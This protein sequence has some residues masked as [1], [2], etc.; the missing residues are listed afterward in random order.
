MNNGKAVIWGTGGDGTFNIRLSVN[1]KEELSDNEKK[2]VE[3]SKKDMK[4]VVTGDMV[5]IGSPEAAG[6]NEVR[7]ILDKLDSLTQAEAS[8]LLQT[9]PMGP[10]LSYPCTYT[11]SLAPL[12]ASLTES[13][14]CLD[15][16]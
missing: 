3:M 15:L 9:N 7:A 1:P 16:L 12:A 5:L 8:S 2:M 6:S 10:L 11:I 4:L 13:N 14:I